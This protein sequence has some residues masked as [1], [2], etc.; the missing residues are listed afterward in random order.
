MD[1]R[2]KCSDHRLESLCSVNLIQS[3]LL[4]IQDLTTQWK[5]CLRRTVTCC[6]RRTARGIS[7]YDVDLA[8]LRILV[9]TVCK[10]SGSAILSSADFLLVRSRA[11][12]AASLALCA[13]TDFSTID[14]R[15]CR[16][17]LKENLQLLT[18]NTVNRTSCLAVSK[19]LLGLTFK[20]WILDLDA[21]DRSQALTDI[22]TA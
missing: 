17:L 22:F 7:L 2:T 21:D 19:L 18:Y 20:L 10:L 1:S 9:R 14:F 13:I 6:L 16:I 11:F 5:D 3:C 12:L 15:N 8:V 4:N